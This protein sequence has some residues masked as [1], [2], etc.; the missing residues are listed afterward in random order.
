MTIQEINKICKGTFIEYLN[1]EFTACSESHIEAVMKIGPNHYQPA[2]FVHGGALISLAETVGSAGSF[3]LVDP[4]KF[5][6]FGSV[7]NSQHLNPAKQGSLHA[8]AVIVVKA[9][10]KH[11]WDVEIMDDEGKL[12]S[13]SRVTNSVKPKPE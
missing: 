4:A 2:G 11:V 8:K 9:D 6:V 10:F 5:N 3:L 12:I 1:I 7:V 13:I